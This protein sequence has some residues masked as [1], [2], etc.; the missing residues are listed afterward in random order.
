MRHCEDSIIKLVLRFGAS[1]L[2]T[3]MKVYYKLL[4]IILLLLFCGNV[5]AQQKQ[6][7]ASL[8]SPFDYGIRNLKQIGTSNIRI[9][10][11]FQAQDLNDMDTWIDC[12]QLLTDNGLTQYS[13]VV[14]YSN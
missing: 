2:L 10:Y 3:N 9:K 13:S 4:F 7:K 5:S 1:D 14:S 11:A 12:G 8:P 6:G